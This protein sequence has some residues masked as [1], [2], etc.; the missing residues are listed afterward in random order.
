LCAAARFR[1]DV[2]DAIKAEDDSLD[3]Y[4]FALNEK[5]NGSVR[6]PITFGSSKKELSEYPVVNVK[7]GKYAE[8]LYYG[9][10][11]NGKL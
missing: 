10:E 8:S 1:I 5:R 7:L 6:W 3:Q 2:P 9:L 4:D 11:L